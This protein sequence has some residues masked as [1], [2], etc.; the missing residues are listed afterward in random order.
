MHMRFRLVLSISIAAAVLAAGF[1][2]A[3]AAAP[4]LILTSDGTV[5]LVSS[6]QRQGFPTLPV[7]TSYGYQL[8]Q[9]RKASSA[10][11]ALPTGPVLSYASGSLVL[12]ADGT[13]Y[14]IENGSKRGFTSA[15]AFLQRGYSFSSVL[16][17]SGNILSSL[18]AG[19]LISSTDNSTP[20]PAPAPASSPL[21]LL[22]PNGGETL[23]SGSKAFIKWTSRG[24]YSVSIWYRDCDSCVQKII[25]TSLNVSGDGEQTFVWDVP[26]TLALGSNYKIDITGYK[27]YE[28]GS[29]SDSSDAGFSI[30]SQA[31]ARLS[32]ELDENT[33][34]VST[35]VSGAK[36]VAV[37]RFKFTAL[38]NDTV[39]SSLTAVSDLSDAQKMFSRLTFYDGSNYLG[40]TP[41]LGSFSINELK[42]PNNTSKSVTVMADLTAGASGILS[43]GLEHAGQRAYGNAISVIPAGSLSIALDP[44]SNVV[45]RKVTVGGLGIA[46]A[47]FKLTAADED[48]DLSKLAL[49]LYSSNPAALLKTTLWQGSVKVGEL[50]GS[51]SK[52]MEFAAPLRINRNSSIILT[53]RVDFAA[54]HV[55]LLGD[56]VAI[57]HDAANYQKTEAVGLTSGATLNPRS[58]LSALGPTLTLTNAAI[59]KIGDTNMDNM[60]MLDDQELIDAHLAGTKLLTGQALDNADVDGD[61]KVTS[62][63]SALVGRYARFQIGEFPRVLGATL[64]A[65]SVPASEAGNRPPG[66]PVVNGFQEM[67]YQGETQK[68]Y[69]F[70]F[71]PDVDPLSYEVWWGDGTKF[72]S[73]IRPHGY[74]FFAQHSW[75]GRG[76]YQV[77]VKAG[78]GR[79]GYG[80]TSFWITIR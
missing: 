67:I 15:A 40:S 20:A 50:S 71:D 74:A 54:D 32:F 23:L 9:I 47:E 79:G 1:F 77:V 42:I 21:K 28:S 13:V 57:S 22:T 12:A 63:D 30:I 53:A 49:K 72:F 35:F 16:K 3:R 60:I 4:D 26:S 76:L 8:S 24:L 52:L 25:T 18:S 69:G 38:G 39:L 14:L 10:D 75:D 61:K 62:A 43:F 34:G 78:D 58:Y 31:Q 56:E 68:I 44:L 2:N 6:G 66:V 65:Q 29:V 48:M 7:F 64:P 59:E 36:S 5:Y 45:E 46:A 33:P 17:D 70:A 80:V 37:A 55:A 41:V 51:G 27:L 73:D 11:L 19:E